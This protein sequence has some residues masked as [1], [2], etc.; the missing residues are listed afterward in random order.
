MRS[1][2]REAAT[3]TVAV[4]F[5]RKIACGWGHRLVLHYLPTYAPETNPIERIWCCLHE[6]ITRCHRCQTM[7]E[8]LDLIF[9]WLQERTHFMVE[10]K[11]YALLP[12][13]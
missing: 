12:A 1:A 10:D 5:T 13:A 8:L 4:V 6:R 2:I 11:V 7:E 3:I 9:A